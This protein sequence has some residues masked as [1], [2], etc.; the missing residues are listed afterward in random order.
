MIARAVEYYR[1]TS[2][3]SALVDEAEVAVRAAVA[4]ACGG[5][6][7]QHPGRQRRRWCVP[8][9]YVPVLASGRYRAFAS[10]SAEPTGN[11]PLEVQCG[12][13]GYLVPGAGRT[14][15]CRSGQRARDL[16]P[17]DVARGRVRRRQPACTHRLRHRTLEHQ[18]R[19]R[20]CEL[21]VYSP[22]R[23]FFLGEIWSAT[24]AVPDL[25]LTRHS[26][27]PWSAAQPTTGGGGLTGATT[28]RLATSA[29]AC[30]FELTVGL[31]NLG[32]VLLRLGLTRE[33]ETVTLLEQVNIDATP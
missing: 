8:G 26:G 21:S 24:S 2:A 3:R 1:N 4:R 32:S 25:Q 11:D 6:A 23:R 17:R 28:S 10:V 18:L 20:R 30:G 7:Q 16:Q 29:S 27:Y 33:G 22:E 12:A 5:V 19:R 9:E 14:R 15:G 31:A 13:A